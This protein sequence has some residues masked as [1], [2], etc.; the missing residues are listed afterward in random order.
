ISPGVSAGCG[1]RGAGAAVTRGRPAGRKGGHISRKGARSLRFGRIVLAQKVGE[2]VHI[3]ALGNAARRTM[4]LGAIGAEQLGRCLA[5]SEVL[6]RRR[7]AR[8]CCR[9]SKHENR[10][11]LHLPATP[12]VP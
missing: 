6:R 9:E 7:S 8:K 5:P 12:W 3:A 11:L 1:R 2:R 10:D 4:T